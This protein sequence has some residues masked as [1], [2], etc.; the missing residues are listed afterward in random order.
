[1]KFFF[2]FLPIYSKTKPVRLHLSNY[3]KKKKKLSLK[4]LGRDQEIIINF[5]LKLNRL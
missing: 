1:M 2:F 5:D 3:E 4:A